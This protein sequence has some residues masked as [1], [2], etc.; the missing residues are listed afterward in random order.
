MRYMTLGV[1]LLPLCE[2]ALEMHRPH[3]AMMGGD[4]ASL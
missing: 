2:P 1:L 4:K 3:N